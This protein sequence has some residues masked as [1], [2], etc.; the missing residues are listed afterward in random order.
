MQGGMLSWELFEKAA[1]NFSGTFAGDAEETCWQWRRALSPFAGVRRWRAV[2]PRI[3]AFVFVLW[4]LT[5]FRTS[6]RRQRFCVSNTDATLYCVF[7]T[8]IRGATPTASGRSSLLT[9]R[10]NSGPLNEISFLQ[11]VNFIA[12]ASYPF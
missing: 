12:S 2:R 4:F 1:R 5:W 8:D 7:Q 3:Q 10:I 6:I 9:S 11:A